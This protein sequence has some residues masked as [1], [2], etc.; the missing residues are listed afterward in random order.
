MKGCNSC[1]FRMDGWDRSFCV[2]LLMF[3]P[4]GLMWGRFC[5]SYQPMPLETFELPEGGSDDI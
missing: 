3:V 4:K 5:T 2:Q 1:V